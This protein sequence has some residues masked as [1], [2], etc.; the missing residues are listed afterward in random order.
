MSPKNYAKMIEKAVELPLLLGERK[1]VE[2]WNEYLS[3]STGLQENFIPFYSGIKGNKTGVVAVKSTESG[4]KIYSEDR[5]INGILYYETKETTKEFFWK[6][7]VNEGLLKAFEKGQKFM[8]FS[9]SN[10]SLEFKGWGL[11]LDYFT[12]SSKKS[13]IFKIKLNLL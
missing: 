7:R 8:V 5:L 10:K 13:A 9:G 4:K 3:K 2:E 11:I 12:S 1:S 6:E